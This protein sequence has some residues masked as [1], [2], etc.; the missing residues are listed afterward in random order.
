VTNGS[1]ADATALIE[2]SYATVQVGGGP[3]VVRNYGTIQ[4]Q[5]ASGLGVY[6]FS[7]GAVTNGSATDTKAVIAAYGGAGVKA[8]AV[9]TVANFG[10]ILGLPYGVHI[11]S[12]GAVTNGSATDTTALIEGNKGVYAHYG[13][14]KVTNFGTIQGRT[15]AGVSLFTGGSVINGSAA[16]TTAL[17]TAYFSGVETLGV[18]TV[19]NFGTIAGTAGEAVLFS[20]TTDVLV[21]EA[22]SVFVGYVLGGGGTLDLASG[23]GKIG[24]LKISSLTGG[25][26]TVSGSMPITTF[27]NF[28]TVE[29]SKGARFTLT[30]AGTIAGGGTATLVDDGVFRVT[31]ALTIG[32]TVS[33]AGTLTF[34]SGTQT[35]NAGATISVAHWSLTG[36]TTTINTSLAYGGAFTEGVGATLA[37][38]AGDKLAL[39]GATALSG[40]IHGAGRVTVSNATASGLTIGGTVRLEDAGAV[41]QTGMVTIGDTTTKAAALITDAGATWTIAGGG[42]IARGAA[43]T[44]TINNNGTLTDQAA[45]TTIVGVK[46]VDSGSMMAAVGTLDFT[47]ALTGTGAMSVDGG[48]TLE[49]D[50][51]TAST[52]SMTFNGGNAVLALK[53]PSAFAATINGFAP[54]DSIDLLGKQATSAKLGAGDTLVIRRNAKVIATL[55]LAGTYTGDTFTAASDGKGGTSITVTSSGA[56]A[57]PSAPALRTPHAFIAAAASLG[58]ASGGAH[59]TTVAHDVGW[60]T[61]LSAPRAMVA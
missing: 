12:G 10:T 49:V 58:A 27:T 45:G 3:A 23:V 31:G 21:V 26:V 22:G 4:G 53:D 19:T 34:A 25:N 36:G 18:A 17:I 33:G 28:G 15:Q 47:R 59:A 55:Q 57:L 39:T 11:R 44:S 60:R 7:G 41:D 52:L 32:G 50:N 13:S 42:G 54:T 30:G 24:S 38:V 43:T 46:V 5:G 2:S 61:I 6:L 16:D 48:A 9:A 56:T 14:A 20:S 35:V 40:T 8:L 1:A 51:T 29:I 37:L